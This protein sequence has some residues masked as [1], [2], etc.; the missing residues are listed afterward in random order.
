MHQT[1]KQFPIVNSSR[2][3]FLVNQ[4]LSNLCYDWM[5]QL[6]IIKFPAIISSNTLHIPIKYHAST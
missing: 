5:K 4:N 2:T 1:P 3:G 6:K